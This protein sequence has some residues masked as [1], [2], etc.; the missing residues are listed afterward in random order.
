MNEDGEKISENSEK[1]TKRHELRQSRNLVLFYYA[2]VYNLNK[3]ELNRQLDHVE[4]KKF[5][6]VVSANAATR[7]SAINKITYE[8]IGRSCQSVRAEENCFKVH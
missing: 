1:E 8:E 2:S 3:N 7:A 6:K 4:E 5:L